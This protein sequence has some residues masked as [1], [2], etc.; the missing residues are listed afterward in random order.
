[1]K[2]IAYSLILLFSINTYAGTTIGDWVLT[3]DIPD[4][5]IAETANS[6]GAGTGVICL[7]STQ[8]CSAFI[9]LSNG[10]EAGAKYPMM[11]NSAVGADLVNSVC[12][13]IGDLHVFLF[14]NFNSVKSS[15]ESGGEIGFA[16]PL[17]SGLFKS[18]RFSTKGATSAIKAA[19]TLPTSIKPANLESFF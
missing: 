4:M 17:K 1:M 19:Q 12:T 18:E 7:I 16:I 5:Q 3:T 2:S 8:Q 11:V 6:G 13:V 14:D 10:C 15:F 9:S